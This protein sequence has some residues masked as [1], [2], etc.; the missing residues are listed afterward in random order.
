LPT[1]K[2]HDQTGNESTSHFRIADFC[3]LRRDHKIAGGHYSRT[4]GDSDDTSFGDFIETAENPAEMTAYSLLKNKLS[5]VLEFLTDRE[6]QVLMHNFP[7]FLQKALHQNGI[8]G[9][10]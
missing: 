8:C 4:V 2:S 1:Q 7:F 5:E 6:K 10:R 3:F 9:E